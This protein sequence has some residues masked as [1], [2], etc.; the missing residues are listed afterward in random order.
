MA[1]INRTKDQA[2]ADAIERTWK[3]V[4]TGEM[5]ERW[6]ASQAECRNV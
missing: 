5:G 3:D 2:D 6:R 1:E 4:H